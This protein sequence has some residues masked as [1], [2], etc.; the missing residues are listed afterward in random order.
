MQGFSLLLFVNTF[1]PQY[2]LVILTVCICCVCIGG[3]TQWCVAVHVERC[4]W[5]MCHTLGKWMHG[6]ISSRVFVVT[7]CESIQLHCELMPPCL[8]LC[9]FLWVCGEGDL[10]LI[11]DLW[12]I[13]LCFT[14]F[15]QCNAF[16]HTWAVWYTCIWPFLISCLN[17]YPC[18]FWDFPSWEIQYFWG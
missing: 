1:T 3:C 10:C 5:P 17:C 18:T 9:A 4:T 8:F 16:R 12:F 15:K 7:S 2:E 11:I 6:L 13:V 14:S